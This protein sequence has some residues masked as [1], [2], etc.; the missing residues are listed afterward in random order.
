M[1]KYRVPVYIKIDGA[2]CVEAE[3]ELE[4][5]E[6]ACGNVRG[7]LDRISNNNSDKVLDWVFDT[8]GESYLRDDESI[9]EIEDDN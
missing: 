8:W 2:V 4:A 6:I 7:I 5:E 9:E 1:T 3:D